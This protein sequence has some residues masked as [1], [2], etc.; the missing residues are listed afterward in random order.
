MSTHCFLVVAMTVHLLNKLFCVIGR[1]ARR[2]FL[3]GSDGADYRV[4]CLFYKQEAPDG[5]L[6]VS[7]SGKTR[8]S[9]VQKIGLSPH[10]QIESKVFE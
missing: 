6:G 10:L 5:A 8:E 7:Q 4:D 9:L 3:G 2:T 1:G